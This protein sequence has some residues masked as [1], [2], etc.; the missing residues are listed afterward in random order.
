LGKV[1]K[2]YLYVVYFKIAAERSE[3][4]SAKREYLEKW[5]GVTVG[6]GFSSRCA[7]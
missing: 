6:G 2:P 5:S 1:L 7:H 4:F 3:P